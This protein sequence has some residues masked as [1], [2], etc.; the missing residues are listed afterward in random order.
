MLCSNVA[1]LE[2]V[3]INLLSN[4]IKFTDPGG[5]VTVSCAQGKGGLIL[6]VEDTG[7]GLSDEEQARIFQKFY[8]VHN[9][10]KRG[11]GTGLGLVISRLIVEGLGGSIRVRSEV[12]QGSCF[13]VHLPITSA[14]EG[15][16]QQP[17]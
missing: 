17:R 12:G 7:I 4:A 2:Q 9:P 3:L 8:T 10:H 13:S 14:A 11:E 5:S 6:A 15:M 1:G 16:A